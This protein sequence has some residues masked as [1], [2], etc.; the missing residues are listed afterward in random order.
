ME[1]N[2]ISVSFLPKPERKSNIPTA[3]LLQKPCNASTGFVHN[4][5]QSALFLQCCQPL[6]KG[7][8][9]WGIATCHEKAIK[10]GPGL[11][12]PGMLSFSPGE[13][14][15]S[16]STARCAPLTLFLSYQRSTKHTERF[17]KEILTS[18]ITK[19]TLVCKGKFPLDTKCWI[20]ERR[21]YWIHPDKRFC[22]QISFS[23]FYS[24]VFFDITWEIF[25]IVIYVCMEGRA[26]TLHKALGLDYQRT[27]L[28][29]NGYRGSWPLLNLKIP[30]KP[31]S[32]GVSW[33]VQ[34]SFWLAGSCTSTDRY[35]VVRNLPQQ[36]STD[37][38]HFSNKKVN[39][40]N[41]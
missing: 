25:F 28:F 38:E 22:P 4:P 1:K 35:F 2:E 10:R 14:M 3:R 29:K 36:R 24:G 20:L 5:L 6:P 8:Q 39:I 12:I 41:G 7:S 16:E 18:W 13:P 21:L 23:S 15:Q 32:M 34:N 30:K 9:L 27:F 17:Q 40:K 11:L 37:T 26:I 31:S 33:S 19:L